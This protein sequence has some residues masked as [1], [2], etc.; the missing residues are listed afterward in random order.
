V[1]RAVYQGIEDE[2]IETLEFDPF[3][4][5]YRPLAKSVAMGE[6]EEKT[7]APVELLP[8]P[9]NF[10]AHIR[11]YESELL[12]AALEQHRYN[13]RNTASALGLSYDQLRGYLRKYKL[14]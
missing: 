6:E 2:L 5:P 1:E 9:A 11:Q 10:K 13:Q 14:P 7:A 12:Q 3:A 4:S 8:G